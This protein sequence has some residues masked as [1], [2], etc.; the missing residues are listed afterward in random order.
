MSYILPLLFII[1]LIFS[2]NAYLSFCDG[3]K[4]AFTLII[5][6]APYIITI[7]IA[8]TLLRQSGL[9]EILSNFLFPVFSFLGLPSEL[10]E[11]ILLRPFSGS[12]SLA[13]A[14]DIISTYGADSYISRLACVIMGSSETVFYVSTI[15]LKEIKDKKISSAILLALLI[16]FIS[17]ILSCLVIKL[18]S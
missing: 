5:D 14:S 11:F 15:Y 4:K 2:K 3:V 10:S 6:I 18:T 1:S 12:G 17:I 7:M 8:I 9:S 13:L 16:S